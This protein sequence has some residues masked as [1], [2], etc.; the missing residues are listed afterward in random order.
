MSSLRFLLARLCDNH[1]FNLCAPIPELVPLQLQRSWDSAVSGQMTPLSSTDGSWQCCA[2]PESILLSW[3]V[4]SPWAVFPLHL[5][6]MMIEDC[7]QNLFLLMRRFSPLPQLA[8]RVQVFSSSTSNYLGCSEENLS[9]YFGPTRLLFPNCT[10][11]Y[12]QQPYSIGLVR[13]YC[14][15]ALCVYCNLPKT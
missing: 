5:L 9:S 4:F 2:G 15:N 7:A 14:W 6:L 12:L 11:I 13:G 10:R 1:N 3:A 8:S